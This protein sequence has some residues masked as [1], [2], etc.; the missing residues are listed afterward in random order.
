[1]KKQAFKKI[2]LKYYGS[3]NLKYQKTTYKGREGATG[4]TIFKKRVKNVTPPKMIT[5]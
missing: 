4:S 5:L 2:M 3:K 1:M